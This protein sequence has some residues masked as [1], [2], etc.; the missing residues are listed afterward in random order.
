MAGAAGAA[1]RCCV[2]I[3]IAASSVIDETTNHLLV[4]MPLSPQGCDVSTPHLSTQPDQGDRE[5]RQ[6]R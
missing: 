5:G 6:I 3:G 4:R 2:A 1:P